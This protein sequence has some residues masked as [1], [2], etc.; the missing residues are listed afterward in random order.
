MNGFS[1]EPLLL[2]NNQS[3]LNLTSSVFNL[4]LVQIR[5]IMISRMAKPVEVFITLNFLP[6]I[7]H[8]LR[9]YW[10]LMKL[11]NQS[12]NMLRILKTTVCMKS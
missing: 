11:V 3:N 9:L 2:L 6:L 12:S 1:N 10:L 7:H 5:S 8:S 4:A